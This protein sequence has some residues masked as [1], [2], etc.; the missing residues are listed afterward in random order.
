MTTPPYGWASGISHECCILSPRDRHRMLC[1]RWVAYAPEVPPAFPHAVHDVCER[2]WKEGGHQAVPRLD[3]YG[4]CP[5][6]SGDIPLDG[7]LIAAHGKWVVGRH[8]VA[9]S[10][11]PCPG[12]G[13]L[14]ESEGER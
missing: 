7:G 10:S 12:E 11:E 5:V 3:A 1:G 9:P 4:K 8:G 6:C 2:L 14:P 13:D